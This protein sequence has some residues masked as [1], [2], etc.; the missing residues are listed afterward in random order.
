LQII[1]FALDARSLYKNG[2]T[3]AGQTD[4]LAHMYNNCL[5][6]KTEAGLAIKA[7]SRFFLF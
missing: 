7:L 5:P 3:L 4:Q 6:V 2:R 1:S